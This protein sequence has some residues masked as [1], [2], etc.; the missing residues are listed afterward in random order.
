MHESSCTSHETVVAAA[1]G[2]S[3]NRSCGWSDLDADGVCAPA[4]NVALCL[5]YSLSQTATS[6]PLIMTSND[7][8][9]VVACANLDTG[10]TWVVGDDAGVYKHDDLK[11]PKIFRDTLPHMC[12]SA[13]S[14]NT[15]CW[16]RLIELD[17]THRYYI[18]DDL[19]D[20]AG[21][22][23]QISDAAVFGPHGLAH[24]SPWQLAGNSTVL[25]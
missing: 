13:E 9:L 18:N 23:F 4:G 16:G 10:G 14:T 17:D 19:I 21:D 15:T 6:S 1:Y 12:R 24:V 20:P 8:N 5:Q 2:E 7:A 3:V 11:E 25:S 22:A